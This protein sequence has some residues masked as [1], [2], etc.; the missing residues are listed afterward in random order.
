MRTSFRADP[1]PRSAVTNIT[2][3]SASR[4]ALWSAAFLAVLTWSGIAPHDYLTWLL[5][6]FPALIAAGVL[7]F[8]RVSF[9]LTTLVYIAHILK[10]PALSERGKVAWSLANTVL[11]P[12]AMPLYWYLHVWRRRGD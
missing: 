4:Q 7:L 11:G 1:P 9:P 8:T 10:N 12:F 6:V 5:E 3:N 2:A